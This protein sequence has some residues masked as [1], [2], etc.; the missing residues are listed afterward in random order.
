MDLSS[1]AKLW[2][3]F[4]IANLA[5]SFLVVL[6]RNSS[7]KLPRIVDVFDFSGKCFICLR[8]RICIVCNFFMI[9]WVGDESGMNA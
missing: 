4:E 1:L 9:L 7:L 2:L 3:L 6:S 5:S 8:I